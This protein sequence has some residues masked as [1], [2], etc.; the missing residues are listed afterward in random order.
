[1][2][3]CGSGNQGKTTLMKIWATLYAHMQ[4]K[5]DIVNA[6]FATQYYVDDSQIT[7]YEY[8]KIP[9]LKQDAST[10][11]VLMF[12]DDDDDDTDLSLLDTVNPESKVMVVFNRCSDLNKVRSVQSLKNIRY[13][14][15]NTATGANVEA[16]LLECLT[17]KL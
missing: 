17:A 10:T 11:L 3:L 2:W 16:P 15:I 9:D 14:N 13:F 12:N 1:M 4:L 7:V 6:Y 8:N 5:P